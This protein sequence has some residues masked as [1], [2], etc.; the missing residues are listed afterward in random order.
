MLFSTNSFIFPFSGFAVNQTVKTHK[1]LVHSVVHLF[2]Y[3]T[4]SAKTYL[5]VTMGIFAVLNING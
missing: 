3:I 1:K 2:F 4:Q 5:S